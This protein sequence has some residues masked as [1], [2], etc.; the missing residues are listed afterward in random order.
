[1]TSIQIEREVGA[2]TFDSYF[3]FCVVRNPWDK[4]VS[5]YMYMKSKR[6]D[7]RQFIGMEDSVSFKNYLSL[8]SKKQH[9]QWMK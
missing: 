1:M 7:L 8:I 5:Q 4:A 2:Y 6:N 9:V 3:K